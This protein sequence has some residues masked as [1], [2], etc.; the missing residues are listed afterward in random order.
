MR[1]A[2]VVGVVTI[3][4]AAWVGGYLIASSP[5]PPSSTISYAG[6]LLYT[7]TALAQA[8]AQTS[9]TSQQSGVET[10]TVYVTQTYTTFATGATTTI[11]LCS[12]VEFTTASRTS[13]SPSRS[14]T[15]ARRRFTSQ[16]A[17]PGL[18][19]QSRPIQYYSKSPRH[20]APALFPLPNSIRVRA[21]PCTALLVKPATTTSWSKLEAQTYLSA[22]IGQRIRRQAQ[23]Q[24]TFQTRPQSWRSSSS[25]DD[26]KP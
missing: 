15:P 19:F 1:P 14:T 20:C 21:T 5:T 12:S 9:S 25:R 13:V 16:M 24:P 10:E 18:P 6:I 3:Q 7:S 22:S 2:A 4:A 11:T 8:P 23:T 26:T 17:L